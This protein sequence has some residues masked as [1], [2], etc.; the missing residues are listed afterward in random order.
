RAAREFGASLDV[1]Q[2]LQVLHDEGIHLTGADCASV[3]L[4]EQNADLSDPGV[5]KALG[6]KRQPGLTP[7]ERSALK[8][9]EP[10]I[11]TDFIREGVLPPH[12]GAR[13]SLVVPIPYQTRQIGLITLHSSHAGMFTDESAELVQMLAVQAG[14]AVQNAQRYQN[15]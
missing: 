7:S 5:Q 13:S 12:E 8:Q 10:F 3:L 1:Q 6:C 14:I 9:G 2:P 15:E 11:V 4:F